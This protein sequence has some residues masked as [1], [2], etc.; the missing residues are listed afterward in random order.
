MSTGT[1]IRPGSS[2]EGAEVPGDLDARDE[3]QRDADD[4]ATV[5]DL[6][7]VGA[8]ERDVDGDLARARLGCG[9]VGDGQNVGIAESGIVTARMDPDA[10]QPGL[11]LP[12][13]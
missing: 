10:F 2:A 1:P 13:G 4:A 5:E 12:L 6:R 9:Q 3:R 7:V 8:S 11:L